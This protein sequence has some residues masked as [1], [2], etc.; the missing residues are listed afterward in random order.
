V[1]LIAYAEIS[2]DVAEGDRPVADILAA[3]GL[4]E[5]QWVEACVFWGQ[6]MAE[7]AREGGRVTLAFSE[8][9]CKAQDGKRPLPPLSVEDWAALTLEIET[10]GSAPR[11]LAARNL[12]LADHSRL[13]RHWAKALASDASLRARLQARFEPSRG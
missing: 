8:A 6:R 12:S 10:H 11:A 9:F 13:V 2:A 1:D 7:D 3:R 5:A 4:T